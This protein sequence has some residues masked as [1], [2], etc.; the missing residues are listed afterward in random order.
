MINTRIPP[1]SIE[2][3][4]S[5]LGAAMVDKKVVIEIVQ[6]LE[7]DDFYSPENQ[8]IYQAVSELNEAGKEIDIITVSDKLK[9]MGKLE[10]IGGIEH[11]SDLATNIPT[12]SNVKHYISIVKGKSVRRKYVAAAVNVID[13]AYNGEYDTVTDFKAD[14]MKQMDIRIREKNADTIQDLTETVLRNIQER[15]NNKTMKMPYG[16]PWL[17]KYT[18]GAHETDLTI[19]AARPSVGK[20][21][22]AM[23]CG[24]KFAE[25]NNYVAIFSLEMGSDQL[26]ERLM[27]NKGRIK[28]DNLRS[29][30]L[31]TDDDNI[32]LGHAINDINNLKLHIYDDIFKIESIRAKCIE[33]KSKDQLDAVIIDYLQ[34]CD[35]SQK[36]ANENDRLGYISTTAKKLAKEIKSPVILLSQLTRTNEHDNRKPKLIDLR[37]SG[38]IEQDAD[39]VFFLHDPEYGK[40]TA[41]TDKTIFDIDLII[42]KQRNGKR[43]I[44][45]TIKF[46]SNTQRW[47]G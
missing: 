22:F 13:F 30:N 40:Y 31:M 38:S 7:I 19:I 9:Y 36:K 5:L 47:E 42:A 29:P 44:E 23:Q 1:N 39:N 46:Y 8:A 37:G 35:T 25:R 33:L 17:D 3:E 28:L 2:A 6:Q 15:Y 21:S 34:L 20:T 16:V 12:V 45:T 10:Q 18:G 14:V 26:V 41:E 4:Q 24:M 11:L 27:A 32:K 43:D